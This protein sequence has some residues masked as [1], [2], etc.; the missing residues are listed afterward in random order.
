[1][2]PDKIKFAL[3]KRGGDTY[4][5]PPDHEGGKIG[6]K[7]MR[8]KYEFLRANELKIW[9]DVSGAGWKV[10]L[11]AVFDLSQYFKA[12]S[13]LTEDELEKAI[14]DEIKNGKPIW[15]YVVK[16][17]RPPY[18]CDIGN[19]FG[20]LA[21]MIVVV[22]IKPK[23][24][25]FFAPFVFG[26][27]LEPAVTF[28]MGFG[29]EFVLARFGGEY[30]ILEKF[31]AVRLPS[32]HWIRAGNVE[33]AEKKLTT[34]DLEAIAILDS[35]SLLKQMFQAEEKIGKKYLDK[36]FDKMEKE[37][38]IAETRVFN[39]LALYLLGSGYRFGQFLLPSP[40]QNF[41]EASK[42]FE[43]ILDPNTTWLEKV[44]GVLGC[45]GYGA[46]VIL[47]FVPGTKTLRKADEIID[48]LRGIKRLE[49]VE[50]VAEHTKQ[51]IAKTDEGFD[52]IAERIRETKKANPELAS[53]LEEGLR[54]V[55]RAK[56]EGEKTRKM[57]SE[58]FT[59]IG[60]DEQLRL[61]QIAQREQD[62]TEVIKF[63]AKTGN[64]M[65]LKEICQATRGWSRRRRWKAFVEWKKVQRMS[66]KQ[67]ENVKFSDE[68]NKLI[69]EGES[70][71]NKAYFNLKQDGFR[72]VTKKIEKGL[73]KVGGKG[74]S[75]MDINK[76]KEALENAYRRL[77]KNHPEQLK[78]IEG[79][80]F[81]GKS[82]TGFGD[83]GVKYLNDIDCTIMPIT[84]KGSADRKARKQ[85][86]K[87]LEQEFGSPLKE[88]NIFV[89]PEWGKGAFN[90]ADEGWPPKLR[91]VYE[92][93]ENKALARFSE[94]GALSKLAVRNEDIIARFP[95]KEEA[96]FF[97]RWALKE[98]MKSKNP[99][100]IHKVDRVLEAA[101]LA[102][103]YSKEDQRIIDKMREIYVRPSNEIRAGEEIL[104]EEAQN[105]LRKYGGDTDAALH[106]IRYIFLFKNKYEAQTAYA[107]VKSLQKIQRLIRIL[108]V[109]S[110]PETPKKPPMKTVKLFKE[111]EAPKK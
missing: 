4:T 95:T 71:T 99:K 45:Y 61:F 57:L 19:D 91:H 46:F 26:K 51:L 62:L 7:E 78:Y 29:T 9:P 32:G 22:V 81:S 55:E 42:Q 70:F 87:Y 16:H 66:G 96:E 102:K 52:E 41:T 56:E 84:P 106:P 74:L 82:A 27:R 54:R 73:Q 111:T 108:Y 60:R 44:G 105:F 68:V 14:I 40:Y 24:P 76:F 11:V 33:E 20:G 15:K 104:V 18:A 8:V 21:L 90:K 3:P 39:P 100:W 94:N 98:F 12:S 79:I 2:G 88:K 86:F 48:G 63:A 36:I 49:K 80:E 25:Q 107:Y 43:I 6:I 110:E 59:K 34:K 1:M 69:D 5:F 35:L 83:E 13:G 58:G 47:D 53:T 93:V 85:F 23:A 97:C 37:G 50:D 31:Y 92:K 17:D 10:G 75:R 28:V 77:K 103:K 65:G 101:G 89:Y 67:I 72:A 109:E 38:R 64:P 30:R